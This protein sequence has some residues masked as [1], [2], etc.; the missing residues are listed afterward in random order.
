[1]VRD[2]GASARSTGRRGR[3]RQPEPGFPVP[4]W[5]LILVVIG[6]VGALVAYAL[7]GDRA[8]VKLAEE[9]AGATAVMDVPM[10]PGLFNAAPAPVRAEVRLPDVSTGAVTL[11]RSQCV[12]I[13]STRKA[14][15]WVAGKSTKDLWKSLEPLLAKPRDNDHM[16]GIYDRPVLLTLDARLPWAQCLKALITLGGLRAPRVH[17]AVKPGDAG[18]TRVVPVF[19]PYLEDRTSVPM[20][21]APGFRTRWRGMEWLLAG[22][23]VTLRRERGQTRLRATAG[24]GE[25]GP[26]GLLDEVSRDLATF[27]KA[28]A[29]HDRVEFIRI[30]ATADVTYIDVVRTAGMC[31]A[32]GFERI[33]FVPHDPELMRGLARLPEVPRG[34]LATR[35]AV[36]KAM[37][38]A[39]EIPISIQAA[40]ETSANEIVEVFVPRDR[41][42]W[43]LGRRTTFYELKNT[44]LERAETK[45]VAE[46]PYASEVG[47]LLTI[48]GRV[49]WRMVQWI[50]QTA[51]SPDVRMNR[52]FWNLRRSESGSE[53]Q[54]RAF[55]PMD[56]GRGFEQQSAIA[57][58]LMGRRRAEDPTKLVLIRLWPE[59][60]EVDLG[61]D[62]SG[63][64]RIEKQFRVLQG[65]NPKATVEIDAG[66]TV[67]FA[68][69]VRAV[70]AIRSAGLENIMFVG[71]PPPRPGD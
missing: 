39:I 52:I 40:D 71:T 15:W 47:V 22:A 11:D 36:P 56:R 3:H 45:R 20:V 68:E 46:A 57:R 14:D 55:L 65:R 44:L 16:F 33:F 60:K 12:E 31:R 53:G 66:A 70:T 37:R 63:Y 30:A 2:R 49:P 18:A 10:G 69:V 1:M 43:C 34:T 21:L 28:L 50:M 35:L 5:M 48:D 51:A 23:Q 17:L 8:A 9:P 42:V 59:W 26:D 29:E 38:R 7:T 24:K 32:A 58:I 6:V 61:T 13:L 62:G 64:A 27:L 54:I 67:T 25:N 41:E 4:P 19:L